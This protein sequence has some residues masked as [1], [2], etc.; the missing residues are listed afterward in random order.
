MCL[1]AGSVALDNVLRADLLAGVRR[2]LTEHTQGVRPGRQRA[3]AESALSRV[4]CRRYP[5]HGG[6]RGSL[7]CCPDAEDVEFWDRATARAESAKRA[8]SSGQPATPCAY[9]R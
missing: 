9:G 6:G 8:P 3:R 4:T 2:L 1:E 5:A 7:I